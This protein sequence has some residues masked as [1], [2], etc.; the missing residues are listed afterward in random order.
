MIDRF[1]RVGPWL[2]ALVALVAVGALFLGHREPGQRLAD[3]LPGVPVA[4]PDGQFHG[5]DVSGQGWGGDFE[6]AGPGGRHV[7]LSQFRGRAVLLTFGYTHCPDACPTTLAKFVQLRRLLGD[8]GK[9]L[10]VIFVTI[11]PARDSADFLQRYVQAFDPGF[12]GLRGSEDQTDRVT[13]A[14]HADYQIIDRGKEELVDHTTDTYLIDTAGRTRM[15]LPYGLTAAEMADD[16]RRIMA[17]GGA[18]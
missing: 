13:R 2:L 7:A 3:A 9:D 14:F 15:V 17:T 18:S 5:R 6:L 8:R 1:R 4:L 12:L 10:Q 11:D 16:V